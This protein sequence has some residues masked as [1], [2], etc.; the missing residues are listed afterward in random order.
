[1][2]VVG[3]TVISDGIRLDFEIIFFGISV[4][5]EDTT[6]NIFILVSSYLWP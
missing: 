2:F 5:T 4:M 6:I 1:M 3:M